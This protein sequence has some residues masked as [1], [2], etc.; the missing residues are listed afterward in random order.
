MQKGE[1]MKKIR[2]CKNCKG[3]LVETSPYGNLPYYCQ[4]CGE[5]KEEYETEII[6]YDKVGYF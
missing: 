3:A 5:D 4:T 1:Y 6:D 2:V